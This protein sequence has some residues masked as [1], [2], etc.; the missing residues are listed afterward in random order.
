MLRA[1][2][3]DPQQVTYSL[4]AAG[5]SSVA[6]SIT[7]NHVKSIWNKQQPLNLQPSTN[8]PGK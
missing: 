3:F 8:F 2:F 4:T 1:V 5:N 6:R 7:V